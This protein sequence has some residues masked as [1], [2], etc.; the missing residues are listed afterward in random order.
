MQMF[1]TDMLAKVINRRVANKRSGNGVDCNYYRLSR[2]VGL[3]SYYEWDKGIWSYL[4]QKMLAEKGFAPKVYG[5][6]LVKNSFAFLTESVMIYH[7]HHKTQWNYEQKQ[8][9]ATYNTLKAE[10]Q[11]AMNSLPLQMQEAFPHWYADDVHEGNLGFKRNWDKTITPYLVD[12]GHYY[13]YDRNICGYNLSASN[14]HLEQN[15]FH[16]QCKEIKEEI[17]KAA[18]GGLSARCFKEITLPTYAAR[19]A[20]TV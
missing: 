5:Y 10:H 19:Y 9:V 13:Y 3:K 14:M 6:C 20:L 17:K 7:T 11:Q 8:Y 15:P 2:K 18:I 16:Q 1:S 4:L 12:V